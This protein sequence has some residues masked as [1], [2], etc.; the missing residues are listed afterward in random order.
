MKKFQ[1]VKVIFEAHISVRTESLDQISPT[2]Q[3]TI[4]EK[5]RDKL[6]MFCQDN[7]FGYTEPETILE[8]EE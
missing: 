1:T 2:L 3:Y 6:E 5:L 4:N 7:S 8:I